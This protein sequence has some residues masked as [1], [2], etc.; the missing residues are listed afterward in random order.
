VPGDAAAFNAQ[1]RAESA[2]WR[3]LIRELG[4]KLD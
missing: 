2:L 1:I 4:I 3:P